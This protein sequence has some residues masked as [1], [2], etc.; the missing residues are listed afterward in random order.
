MT[1]VRYDMCSTVMG[2]AGLNIGCVRIIN[3]IYSSDNVNLQFFDNIVIEN[4]PMPE[5][6]ISLSH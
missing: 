6:T 3:I 2:K 4:K 5:S 1:C